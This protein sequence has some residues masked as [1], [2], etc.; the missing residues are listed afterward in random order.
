MIVETT[1]N[2]PIACFFTG[3]M[4]GKTPVFRVGATPLIWNS[5]GEHWWYSRYRLPF[6]RMRSI[7]KR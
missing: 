6:K 3:F 5:H 1:I 4:I 2:S 7:G